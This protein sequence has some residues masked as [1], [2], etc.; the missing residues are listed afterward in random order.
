MFQLNIYEICCII[1]VVYIFYL[2]YLIY[3]V[4]F[5]SICFYFL[6]ILDNFELVDIYYSQFEND[7]FGD[8]LDFNEVGDIVIERIVKFKTLFVKFVSNFKVFFNLGILVDDEDQLYNIMQD[9]LVKGD[10]VGQ[11]ISLLQC[12]D[13]LM[14]IYM[15]QMFK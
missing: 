1:L 13:I 7:F 3:Y 2:K 10:D 6:G 11:G 15:L 5:L 12:L 4:I 9:V 8:E 14:F